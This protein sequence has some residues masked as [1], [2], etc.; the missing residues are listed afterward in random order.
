MHDYQR[1]TVI[2]SSSPGA[3]PLAD[4]VAAG[5]KSVFFSHHA[6]YA[7]VTSGMAVADARKAFAGATHYLLDTRLMAAWAEALAVGGDGAAARH[8]AARLREFRKADAAEF[9]AP[10]DAADAPAAAA[11]A[12]LPF[13]CAPPGAAVPWRAFI[14]Q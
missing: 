9:F 6:D 7:A 3:A 2:F 11:S 13:Q 4:R 10:C 5:Q 12:P 14:G 1:V 8:V